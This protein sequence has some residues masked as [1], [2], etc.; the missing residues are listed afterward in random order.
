MHVRSL[1]REDPLEEEMAINSSILALEIPWTE[2][3]GGLQFMGSK[4]VRHD[5]ATKPE[6]QAQF[7]TLCL[8]FSLTAAPAAAKSLQSCPTRCN[9]RDGSPPGS[10]VPGILQA[11]T[12]EWVAKSSVLTNYNSSLSSINIHL[13]TGIHFRVWNQNQSLIQEAPKPLLLSTHKQ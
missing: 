7:S 1:G 3:P 2:E 6:Q 12:L 9:P 13:V 4:R 11:R 10:A 8:P 5:L